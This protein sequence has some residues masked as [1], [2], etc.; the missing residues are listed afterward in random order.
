M[1]CSLA[2]R[3]NLEAAA[4][5]KL[6]AGGS[7]VQKCMALQIIKLESGTICSQIASVCVFFI[8]IFSVFL[9]QF[10]LTGIHQH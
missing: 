7:Y 9:V 4:V 1:S 2:D 6:G 10:L 3:Y 5:L 8:E